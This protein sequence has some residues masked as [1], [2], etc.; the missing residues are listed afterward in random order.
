[1]AFVHY[2][3]RPG[4]QESVFD[5]G[6]L[7]DLKRA[8]GSRPEG[9]AEQK[10]VAR[11][12]EAL[13]LQMMLKRMREAIPGSGLLDSQQTKMLQSMGDEQLALQLA[14]P[15]IGLAQALLAQMRQGQPAAAVQPAGDALADDVPPIPL[16]GLPSAPGAGKT[17]EREVSALLDM[18]R[19]NQARER[20]AAAAE[21]VPPHVVDF[22][23]RM[24]G[25]ANHA[26]RESGVPARLILGQAA[27]ESGWGRREILHPDGR[28]SHNV[29]GIKAGAGWKGDV[30]EVTTTEY[31]DGVA[32][33]M[34]QPFR[35]YGSYRE[36]FADYARLIGDSPRYERVVQA[37][38]EVEAARR[39]QQAGYA[40]DPRYADKLIQVMSQLQASIGAL[41]FSGR[42]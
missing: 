1:V 38:N 40:T 25:A 3:P 24:A 37:R 18:L 21:G 11:Q 30:V 36:A 9:T 20:A 33:K 22:V 42:R 13:F 26:A 2:T 34:V 5:L 32:R 17:Q 7:A 14:D 15:G 8:A 23:S 35:S 39:I 19:S 10:Q 27:L 29:F 28:T 31:V 6:R 12:F 41:D 16:A 4:S